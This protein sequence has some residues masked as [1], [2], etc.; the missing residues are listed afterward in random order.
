LAP[1]GPSIFPIASHQEWRLLSPVLC[2]ALQLQGDPDSAYAVFG[3]PRD[4]PVEIVIASNVLAFDTPYRDIKDATEFLFSDDLPLVL[5]HLRYA[6]KFARFPRGYQSA[7]VKQRESAQLTA[8]HLPEKG[9][10]AAIS[11]FNIEAALTLEK[12]QEF[13]NLPRGFSVPVYS[14]LLLDAIEA[15]ALSDFKK[16][17]LYAAIAVETMAATVLDE[18]YERQLETSLCARRAG[19]FITAAYRPS[20]RGFESIKAKSQAPPRRASALHP[21]ALAAARAKAALRPDAGPP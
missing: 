8:V 3:G 21:W 12:I 6:S 11:G 10:D 19:W 14:D 2:L 20:V 7:C 16:S 15:L 5:R 13:A 1:G 9:K 17:V 4:R 18:E